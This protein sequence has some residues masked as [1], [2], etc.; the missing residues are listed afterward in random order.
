[1]FI[2]ASIMPQYYSRKVNLFVALA[3]VARISH[4]NVSFLKMMASKVDKIEKLLTDD[5]E[6]YNYIAPD[7]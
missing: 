5:F 4:I 7:W 3:P 6:M 1:M 2:G